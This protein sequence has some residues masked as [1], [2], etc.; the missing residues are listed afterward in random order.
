M[1]RTQPRYSK[2]VFAK[3]GD[4][5][6]EKKILRKLTPKD[7]GKFLAIDIDTGEYE[8]ADAVISASEPLLARLPDAQIWCIRI[9]HRAVHRFG[10]RSANAQA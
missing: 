9:G 5:I 7:V 8:V 2:D 4:A 3:R 10:P 1:D 6:Y